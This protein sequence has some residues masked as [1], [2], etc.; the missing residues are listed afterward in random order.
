MSEFLKIVRANKKSD[1]KLDKTYLWE[2]YLHQFEKGKTSFIPVEAFNR[3]LTVNFNE[4]VKEGVIFETVVHDY[5]KN[6]DSIQVRWFA[7]IEKVCGYRVLAQFIGADTKF[8]LNILSD[9]M[10]GLAN[11]AMSDPNMDKIVYAPPLAINEEYQNDMVNYVN[12][13]IDGE[14][15]GQTS[16][17]PK[18]DEGKALLSKHRF[19]VGQRLELL[20][21][22]NSTEIRVAR[23][24]EIC[25]RRMNV[26]ITKKDFP[27]SLPDADDDRQVFSSGS[28]YWID[29]GSFFIFPVGF[30]AVN[31]YQLNA[32][33]EYI[34]HTNKIAQAIK[35]GENPRYDSDDVTFDQLAKDPIDPMIWRKV[36]VGQK[37][38]LID[39]LAQQFNNLHVASILKFCKTEGYLIVGMDGPDA[40]ED[41]F[42]I[43][44]N[45]TF[46]FPVG[47]AEK[48]NLELVPPDEFKGTFRWDEYLEKESAETLPLDLFKP[49][50]SQERLDKFKV[51][52]RL[53]A[54][55]MCE[56]QFI[57]PATVKSVHGRLINVN[58][59]GWDEEF[60]ELYDVDSHDIL[61][62]GWC[63]AHS[64]VL[65]PPKKY[66]Y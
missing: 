41:S 22:S 30:A 36:K 48:Y 24:Q 13:C 65:Q 66:N 56:N 15:V 1:R 44:I 3:N 52:L 47:Y 21:Y 17:S 26:S 32:K 28:Q 8:W 63:E 42:P 38:E 50:P 64:Y 61:P 5:D 58:F 9:D 57:C 31:G 34:E 2:S 11:A 18:F 33:K 51:G 62:I 16:L 55:D 25:G 6:C 29:E 12:N 27:E 19:K 23:I 46:M 60:D 14:I 49:M 20:N 53:E 40:L 7:R 39:P 54:A 4:C 43:H 35:N 37:F 59:D 10:F 45:N